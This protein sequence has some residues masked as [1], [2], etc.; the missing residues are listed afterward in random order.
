MSF[1]RRPPIALTV[2][3]L[4]IYGCDFSVNAQT[5]TPVSTHRIADSN[6]DT[7]N[8]KRVG[9]DSSQT[10]TLTLDEAIRRA[11][12]NNNGIEIA[13]GDVKIAETRLRSLLGVYDPVFSVSPNYNRTSQ[14]GSRPTNNFSVNLVGSKLFRI[15]GRIEHFFNIR[16]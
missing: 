6:S 9:I 4:F 8:L 3:I 15:G 2:I 11:L 5:P 13:R 7:T 16:R 1:F 10:M 14:N 12:E